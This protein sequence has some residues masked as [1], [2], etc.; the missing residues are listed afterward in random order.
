MVR[1]AMATKRVQYRTLR[2]LIIVYVRVNVGV[3]QHWEHSKGMDGFLLR[4]ITVLGDL[5][6]PP[7][8]IPS[9]LG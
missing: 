2:W 5:G 8:Q 4:M 9:T 1:P 6:V 7:Y 3:S